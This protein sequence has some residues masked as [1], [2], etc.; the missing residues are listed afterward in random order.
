MLLGT[1]E[2][3]RTAW[4]RAAE[5]GNSEILQKLWDLAKKKLTT[6]EVNNKLLLGTDVEGRTA[7][8]RVAQRGN[9][10]ILQKLWEW[11]TEKLTTE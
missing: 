7:R 5:R 1:N 8:H 4:H 6:E 2:D 11:A 9:S 3:G 10:E